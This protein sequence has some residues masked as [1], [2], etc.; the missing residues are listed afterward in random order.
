MERGFKLKFTDKRVVLIAPAPHIVEE[1]QDLS[2]FD[3]VCRMNKAVP[4][5]KEVKKT[6]GDRTDVLYLTPAVHPNK[7]WENTKEL[8]VKPNILFSTVKG[9]TL[10][11][12]FP[13]RKKLKI[14]DYEHF[15]NI[16]DEIE[17]EPNMGLIAISDI[18]SENPKE[19]YITGMTFYQTGG[20]YKGYKIPSKEI[21]QMIKNKGN[22]FK[23]RQDPQIEYFKK[24]FKHKVKMDKK[25]TEVIK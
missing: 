21:E 11:K 10:E 24:H 6:T 22:I 1:K 16:W 2:G 15:Y 23:H 9:R 3:V 18:L 17:S 4:I 25:L 12:Y 20:Y 5:P 7:D 19:L 8:R 13:Y 14:I